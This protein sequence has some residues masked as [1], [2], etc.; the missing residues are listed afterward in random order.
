MQQASGAAVSLL[1]SVVLDGRSPTSSRIRA[2]A[3]LLEQSAVAFE[4]EDLEMRL[5]RLEGFH[6]VEKK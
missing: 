3:F 6:E 4:I 2:A 1:I 5:S